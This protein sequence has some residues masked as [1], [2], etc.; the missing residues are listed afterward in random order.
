MER[1]TGIEPAT[2]SLEGCDSTTELLPPCNMRDRLGAHLPDS[3]R[4]V[5]LTCEPGGQ[6]RIRTPVARK[7]RQVY[8]LLPLTARPP[9]RSFSRLFRNSG[10]SH[11][12]QVLAG[13]NPAPD[14][15]R[16]YPN[17]AAVRVQRTNYKP[18]STEAARLS[19][20][21]AAR[22]CCAVAISAWSWRRDSNPRP[23]DYKS[24]ALPTEL[25][26]RSQTSNYRDSVSEL[27]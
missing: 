1:E 23:S 9:V 16:R 21:R 27:Q 5:L 25:R 14:R 11:L 7:E 4:C 24:D 2:N 17:V 22:Q 18:L 3:G 26:Q 20:A 8:S 6:G 10:V 12:M 13:L 19:P 15:F